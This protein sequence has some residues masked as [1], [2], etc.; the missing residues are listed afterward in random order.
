MLTFRMNSKKPITGACILLV[1]TALIL[2][3]SCDKNTSTGPDTT[4]PSPPV[5]KFSVSPVV[6]RAPLAVQFNDS[7][8]GQITS[9]RWDFG[10]GYTSSG[11][12]PRHTYTKDGKFTVSL[13]VTGPGGVDTKTEAGL[14]QVWPQR[15]TSFLR[16]WATPD[17][18]LHK[19]GLHGE[20]RIQGYGGAIFAVGGYWFRKSGD[21]YAYIK[22]HCNTNVPDNY[23]GLQWTINI[24][25]D[26]VN[27]VIGFTTP[28]SC[29]KERSGCY[30]GEIKLYNVPP[31][32]P[33]PPNSAALAVSQYVE[34]CWSSGSPKRPD[35]TPLT[36]RILS[37]TETEELERAIV[38]AGGIRS[39]PNE[40]G[41]SIDA[42][43]PCPEAIGSE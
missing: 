20:A 6:G 13:T 1:L 30:Y 43:G 38:A 42:D 2:G 32:L 11:S 37:E 27:E 24:N 10:D 15:L 17:N 26:Q 5:A 36:F 12:H 35:D 33:V 7:S 4:K 9:Y 22:A 31:R 14:V 19:I 16:T 34:I 28:Y 8:S 25:G 29:F 3:T 39:N 21:S 40:R 23:L 18:S 41:F